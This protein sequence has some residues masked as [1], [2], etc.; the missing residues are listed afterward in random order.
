MAKTKIK[1]PKF[2]KI[3]FLL[4]ILILLVAA[5]F[6]LYKIEDYLVFLGD[7]GRD[8][9]VVKRM[10]VDHKFTLLGPA[11]SIGAF[12]LGPIYYYFMLPFLWLFR[13]NPVGP[14]V[15]VSLFGI[16]TVFLV[17]LTGKSFFNYQVGLLAAALYSVSPLVIAHSRSSWNPNLMPFFSLLLIFLMH[18][19][20]DSKNL[21]LL[22][23]IGFFAGVALQ[24]HYLATFLI[25]ILGVY[26][27]LFSP[28]R[29]NF[30][31]YLW[32]AAGFVFGW[33]PF[34]L[35]ELRHNFPNL[36]TLYWFFKSGKETGLVA[37]KFLP[38]V[39]DV[40]KR[41]FGHLVAGSQPFL[42][43][44]LVFLFLPIFVINWFIGRKERKLFLT[45]SLIAVWLLGGILL[46]GFY[47]N[48][49]Y[50]YYFTFMF[51]LPFLIIAVVINKIFQTGKMGVFLGGIVF[52]LLILANL[53][54]NPFK[55][56][57]N[58]QLYQTKELARFVI[59]KSEGKPFNFALVA[60]RNTDQAYR[61]FMEVWKRPPVIIEN[62]FVDPQRK[63]V[64]DQLLVIC[65]DSPCLPVGHPLW[66][67]A[68]FGMSQIEGQ[69]EVRG[70]KVFKLIHLQ[71]K[72]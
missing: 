6:R 60:I 2:F 23:L 11:A 68:G 72:K 37:S 64:T 19:A 48:N 15:M 21:K 42:S 41:I 29:T 62:P 20:V 39:Y 40:L 51:A 16:A 50:D 36:R 65:E 69:W 47:K 22:G 31:S 9:L 3:E 26:F 12:Y 5:F 52:L 70:L 10:I 54:N 61:Y 13:L 1:I 66:E 38:T 49:I 33:S 43:K 34:L 4:L 63:T 58:R 14:A 8:V 35:F 30:K 27:V 71:K 32:L 67:I 45:Y 7:E 55:N 46:F 18:K 57:A 44:I 59:E 17:Y 25:L 24:L 28:K 56:T 53:N